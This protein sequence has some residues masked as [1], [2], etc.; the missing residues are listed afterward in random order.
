[1][2]YAAQKTDTGKLYAVKC[3]GRFPWLCNPAGGG[4]GCER[5][6]VPAVATRA[7]SCTHVDTTVMQA[8]ALLVVPRGCCVRQ[9][10]DV[11]SDPPPPTPHRS[12][13]PATTMLCVWGRCGVQTSG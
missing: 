11:F 13:L 3:M 6:C 2:V 7:G 4:C 10:R 12:R 8:L 5:L 9:S 1:M